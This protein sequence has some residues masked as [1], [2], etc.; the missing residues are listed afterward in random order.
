M[1]VPMICIVS[2]L[3]YYADHRNIHVQFFCIFFWKIKYP[4]SPQT[5]FFSLKKIVPRAILGG[6]F[7]QWQNIWTWSKVVQKMQPNTSSEIAKK[8]S[9]NYKTYF[10]SISST[11][12]AYLLAKQTHC[13]KIW[14]G[15]FVDIPYVNSIQPVLVPFMTV[16]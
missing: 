6:Q 7:F 8:F 12:K 2:Y 14:Q 15:E 11:S 16:K 4:P 1:N 9:R 5:I 13:N 3:A 10:G